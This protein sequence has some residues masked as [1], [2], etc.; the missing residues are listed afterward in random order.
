[1]HIL[2]KV[3]QI[4]K[5]RYICLYCLGRCF[6]LLSTQTTNKER[7][8]ALLLTQVMESHK[9]YL[10]GDETAREDAL[11]TLKILAECAYFVPAQ[12][13]LEKEG[14]EYNIRTP[15]KKCYLCNNIFQEL[16]SYINPILEEIKGIEFH[17]FLVGT[18]LNPEIGNKEDRFKAKLNLFEAES[19][20]SHF[21]RELGKL[22]SSILEKPTEFTYPHLTIIC[23]L[24]YESFSVNLLIRSLFIYGRYRKLIRGIPQTRWPCSKCDGAGC[25][26]CNYT[27]KMYQTS[28]EEL[29]SL[30]FL[31]AA[32]A[33]SSKFHGAGREDIDVRMLGSGRPFI[34]E[35]INSKIRTLDLPRL[36]EEVNTLN[37]G[38]VE[39]NDLAHSNKD[40]VINIK[41]DAK[42]TTKTYKALIEANKEIDKID[43][44][45][46]LRQL[47]KIIEGEIIHQKTPQRVAHRRANKVRN[48]KIYKIEG[49]YI[50]PNLFEFIIQTQG[51][52][53]IKELI[54]SDDGR[55]TPSFSEIFGFTLNCK[56][57]DVIAIDY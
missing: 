37:K 11:K 43:F 53:Y 15:E 50:E 36:K 29:I 39:I 47:K 2:E 4:Y 33:D 12:K 55:T 31:K 24:G 19:F 35:L 3:Q 21:N 18:S 54:T 30:P 51:G 7:G 16:N 20:K 26:Y 57:L 45:E 42:N 41:Q 28:V 13:V 46:K 49:S 40:K 9:N 22:L 25:E 17:N 34:L 52:T 32:R 48:K 14:Y 10:S 56:T 8:E 44:D 5:E 27:G 38:K 23:S 1:M 6:S